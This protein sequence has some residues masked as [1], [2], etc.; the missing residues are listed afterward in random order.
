MSAKSHP[1]DGSY[2]K[3][4]KGSRPEFDELFQKKSDDSSVPVTTGVE[5]QR[6]V[7]DENEE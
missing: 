7:L 5:L 2:G 6:R 4:A 1:G 3:G